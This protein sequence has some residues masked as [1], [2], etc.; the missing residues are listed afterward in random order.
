MAGIMPINWSS[1]LGTEVKWWDLNYSVDNGSSYWYVMWLHS[2]GARSYSWATYDVI[3][4]SDINSSQAFIKARACGGTFPNCTDLGTDISDNVFSINATCPGGVA[5]VVP[6]NLT[7]TPKTYSN[8]TLAITLG[9]TDNSSNE[10]GFV[11]YKRIQGSSQWDVPSITMGTGMEYQGL[12][13]GTTYE[14]RVRSGNQYGYSADS[15]IATA[16]VGSTAINNAKNSSTNLANISKVITRDLYMGSTGDDVK[17]LQ[18]LLVNE[19]GYSADLI[20][21]Y[22]GR[23]TR[24]AVKNLQEKYGIKPTYGYF[25]EITRKTLSALISN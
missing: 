5:P 10:L 9:W 1:P 20:T 14:F 13:S 17:Q 23:I 15:N 8:G 16:T 3:K 25:G 4:K 24:D 2:Y 11:A 18:A 12:Q 19:V 7:A 21:G 6:T 22:F